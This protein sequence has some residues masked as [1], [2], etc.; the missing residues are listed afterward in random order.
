MNLLKNAAQAMNDNKNGPPPQIIIETSLEEKNIIIK[1][2]DN[3]PG[4]EKEKLKYVFEPF[5]TTKPVGTGTGLGLSIS[6]YIITKN[7]RGDITVNSEPGSGST[8]TIRL[9]LERL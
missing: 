4:I 8:F 2:T 1:I 6:Y 3:G 9:P 5:Y 7:H